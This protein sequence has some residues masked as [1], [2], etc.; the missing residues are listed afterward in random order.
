LAAS[1]FEALA[2]ERAEVAKTAQRELPHLDQERLAEAGEREQDGERGRHRAGVPRFREL[3]VFA[4]LAPPFWGRLLC[5]VAIVVVVFAHGGAS[6]KEPSNA[7]TRASTCDISESR[8]CAVS[9][10]LNT[11]TSRPTPIVTAKPTEKICRAGAARAMNA[12]ATCT[13]NST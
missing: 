10:R 8:N 11:T 7:W 6:S 13:M 12:S 2:G 5:F 9:G 3:P 4:R 1:D